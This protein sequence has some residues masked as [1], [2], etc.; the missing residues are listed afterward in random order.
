MACESGVQNFRVSTEHPGCPPVSPTG[1]VDKKLG[2]T[3]VDDVIH[4]FHRP[5]YYSHS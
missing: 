1:A 3:C 4:G 5:Y 2:L